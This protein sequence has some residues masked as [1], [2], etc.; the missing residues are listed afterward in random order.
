[1]GTRNS[2]DSAQQ[3]RGSHKEPSRMGPGDPSREQ[4]KGAVRPD[5]GIPQ[6]ALV[7]RICLFLHLF[8]IP[9]FDRDFNSLS[10]PQKPHVQLLSGLL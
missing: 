1:M 10:L 5:K 8:I 7:S 3:D 2:L 6:I 9:N 4:F